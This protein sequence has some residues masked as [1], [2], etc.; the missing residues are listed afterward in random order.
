METFKL[1]KTS[2][3]IG[4]DASCEM[5]KRGFCKFGLS[6]KEKILEAFDERT[7]RLVKECIDSD[8]LIIVLDSTEIDPRYWT[9]SCTED[10]KPFYRVSV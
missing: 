2:N 10:Y 5:Y 7:L 8:D 4:C 1:Q 3:P 9:V 6:S